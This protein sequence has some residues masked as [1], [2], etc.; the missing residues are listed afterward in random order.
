M[1]NVCV[2]LKDTVNNADYFQKQK[3]SPGS[4]S[5]CSRLNDSIM[6]GNRHKNDSFILLGERHPCNQ[7]TGNKM[8]IDGLIKYNIK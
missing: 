1:Q 6:C 4:D 8:N 2:W 5:Q 3:I 7:I